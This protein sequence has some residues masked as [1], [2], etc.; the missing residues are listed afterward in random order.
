MKGLCMNLCKWMMLDMKLLWS[1]DFVGTFKSE[2]NPFILKFQ[3]YVR[4]DILQLYKPMM[5]NFR[6]QIRNLHEG[7]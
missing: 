6:C 1:L 4:S 2:K 3:L 7:T 5:Q